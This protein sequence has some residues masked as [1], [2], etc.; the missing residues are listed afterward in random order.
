MEQL[1]GEQLGEDNLLPPTDDLGT[2]NLTLD[3]TTTFTVQLNGAT[4]G[5]FDQLDVTGTVTDLGDADLDLTLGFAPTNSD[6]FTII[7]NDLAD[8]VTGVFSNTGGTALNHG[9]I[10]GLANGG[11]NYIFGIY[12]NVDGA[13]AD[14]TNAATLAAGSGNDVVLVSFGI[15][16]TSVEIVGGELVVTDINGGPSD[17]NITITETATH[18]VITAPNLALST[19]SVGASFVDGNTIQVDK[20]AVTGLV[21]NTLANANDTVN[22]G[23]DLTFDGRIEINAETINLGGNVT[24]DDAGTAQN[25]DFNGAVTLTADV[26]VDGAAVTFASTTDGGQALTVNADGVTTFTGAVGSGRR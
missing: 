7:D 6:T 8:A 1:G 12:Y 24:A 17:D 16:E 2:G 11:N 23:T 26:T 21:V 13:S 15:A 4:A 22:T 18:Y 20:T 19:S 5:D 10:F 9:D 14:R 25:I 3:T